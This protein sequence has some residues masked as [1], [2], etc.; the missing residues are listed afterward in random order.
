MGISE[1]CIAEGPNENLHLERGEMGGKQMF[2]LL[3]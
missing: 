1:V 3:E 2:L